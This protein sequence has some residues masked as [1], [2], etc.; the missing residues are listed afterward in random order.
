MN[1][2]GQLLGFSFNEPGHVELMIDPEKYEVFLVPPNDSLA[3]D[4]VFKSFG[5]RTDPRIP[6]VLL[7]GFELY[8][9]ALLLVTSISI[10]HW[11][12]IFDDPVILHE[13]QLPVV[14]LDTGAGGQVVP[15]PFNEESMKKHLEDETGLF[16]ANAE[17]IRIWELAPRG[18]TKQTTL[19]FDIRRAS[20]SA[21][22]PDDFILD[23]IKYGCG[24]LDGDKWAEWRKKMAGS[25]WET[26]N[27]LLGQGATIR[28]CWIGFYEWQILGKEPNGSLFA[29]LEFF[30]DTLEDH[31]GRP[32]QLSD[33]LYKP[34][35]TDKIEKSD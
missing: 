7:R 27:R 5:S 15:L 24:L 25:S 9:S 29:D 6:V 3:R 11:V 17:R 4:K 32:V 35:L 13:S 28:N 8:R 21:E 20:S 16:Q 19:R 26:I 18:R 34:E 2:T 14:D 22:K 10:P 31:L 33:Y 1:F 23:A 30:R 12:F